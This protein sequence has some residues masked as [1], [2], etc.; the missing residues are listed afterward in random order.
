VVLLLEKDVASHSDLLQDFEISPSTLSFHLN[1][2]VKNKILNRE[3]Q[4]RVRFYSIIEKDRIIETLI[5]YRE[6]FLDE[7]V[8]RFA[9]VWLDI[10]LD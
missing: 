6:S 10:G 5:T 7:V 2:L 4:G 1:K 3:K 8:D 9:D